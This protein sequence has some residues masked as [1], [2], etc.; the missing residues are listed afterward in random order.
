MTAD[1]REIYRAH[2]AEYHRLVSAED[3]DGALR[4]AIAGVAPL[5]GRTAVEVGVG[6]GRVTELLLGAGVAKL[7]GVDVSAAMLEVARRSLG[8]LAAPPGRALLL[9]AGEAE[10]LPV[11]DGFADLAVAGWVFGH[12]T[13]WFP[14]S[15]K[16]HVDAALGECARAT[17][18]GAF[19][20][21]I[22]TLGTG[23]ESPAPPN[24]GL[25]AYYAHLEGV[26]GFRRVELRTDYAFA[27]PE[28]AAETCRLFFGDA[29]ADEILRRRWSRVP[30]CTGLWWRERPETP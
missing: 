11:A 12:A 30:E 14:D 17:R 20:I 9:C 21:V 22:E 15:W 6:T 28:I 24:A 5:A 26:H 13:H 16:A 3:A 2:A 1:Y 23:A 18:K 7:V 29:F 25:A 8:R 10:R 27:S 4:R 19:H